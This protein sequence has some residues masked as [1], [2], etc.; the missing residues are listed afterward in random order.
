MVIYFA[1]VHN[2]KEAIMAN[3]LDPMPLQVF[4]LNGDADEL[5]CLYSEIAVMVTVLVLG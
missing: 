4:G 5:C 3:L 1:D 2:A